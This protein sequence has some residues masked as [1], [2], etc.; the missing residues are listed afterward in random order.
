MITDLFFYQVDYI[1]NDSLEKEW[2]CFLFLS[3]SRWVFFIPSLT[4]SESL[5]W[6]KQESYAE[7][8]NS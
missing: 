1:M 8:N 6:S 7:L 3:L 5:T 2:Q 4:V